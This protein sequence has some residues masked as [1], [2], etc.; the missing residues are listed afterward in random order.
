M[1][2]GAE[3]EVVAVTTSGDV[4][5]PDTAWGEGAFV[6][7]LE[8]A[9]RDGRID[10]AV[11]SAKD[12]PTGRD[13]APDLTV[14]AYVSRADARDAHRPSRRRGADLDRGHPERATIGTDSPA[15]HG[16]PAL[17]APRPAASGR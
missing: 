16:L 8:T 9:L 17:P 5:A 12:M 10:V 2:V 11:H 6:D 1:G 4:R 13:A 3:V 15:S 14:A 7:A